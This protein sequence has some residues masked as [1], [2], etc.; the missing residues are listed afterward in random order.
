MLPL[1]YEES[2]IETISNTG[3]IAELKNILSMYEKDRQI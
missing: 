2:L 3:I 1:S